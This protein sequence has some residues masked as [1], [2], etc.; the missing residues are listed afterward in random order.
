M[1]EILLKQEKLK[2]CPW[3]NA[4]PKLIM[5]PLWNGSHGYYG[6]YKYFIA[7]RNPKCKI[8]PRSHGC[9]TIIYK[10][11]NQCIDNAI[12]DW[13]ER[14]DFTDDESSMKEITTVNVNDLIDKFTDMSRREVLLTNHSQDDLLNQII[15]TIV[16]VALTG[17]EK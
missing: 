12:K 8:N 17:K 16:K 5:E 13:N 6:N 10:T 1:S 11:E 7:C 9:N 3:C 15:G 4:T 2:S 14:K